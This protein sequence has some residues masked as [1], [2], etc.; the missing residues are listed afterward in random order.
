MAQPLITPEQRDQIKQY[1]K[2]K[3]QTRRPLQ[4][5]DVLK[6]V[7]S[8][9][10]RMLKSGHTYED[11]AQALQDHNLTVPVEVLQTYYRAKKKKQK[12]LA[13]ELEQVVTQEQF[14]AI[15]AGFQTLAQTRKGCNLREL[16]AALEAEIDEDLQANWTFEHI[17]QWLQADFQITISP[18]SL[19]SYYR[20]LKREKTVEGEGSD[21]VTPDPEIKADPVL[22]EAAPETVANLAEE[23]NL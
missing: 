19:R 11:I 6:Q 7:R 15:V 21:P 13:P 9:V 14:D 22:P 20:A 10:Q 18:A 3:A 12:T 17:V 1:L 23:F 5:A 2:Q 8:S 16:I 4:V